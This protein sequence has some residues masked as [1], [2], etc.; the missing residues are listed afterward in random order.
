MFFRSF[1]KYLRPHKVRLVLAVICMFG[2]GFFSTYNILMAKP[3]LDVLFGLVRYEERVAEVDA[4]IKRHHGKLQ[5]LRSSDKRRDR[6]AARWKSFYYPIEHRFRVR[7]FG[8]FLFDP[9]LFKNPDKLAVIMRDGQDPLTVHLRERF[10]PATLRLLNAYREGTQP[11][12][13]LLQALTNDLN[14]VLMG[15]NL[16]DGDSYRGVHLDDRTIELLAT[17]LREEGVPSAEAFEDRLSTETLAPSD[18]AGTGPSDSRTLS[19][20]WSEKISRILMA[21]RIGVSER[22]RNV[23]LDEKTLLLLAENPEGGGNLIRLNRYLLADAYPQAMESRKRASLYGYASADKNKRKCL[24]LIAG[25]F[26]LITLCA[27]L[28]EYG[29]KY[30][31]AYALFSAVISLKSD[32]FRHIMRQD[33][34]FFT[35][36]SVGF[37]MSRITSDVGALRTM[38]DVIIK[39]A[40]LEFIRLLFLMTLLLVINVKLTAY[41]FLGVL[42]IIGLLAWFAQVIKRVTRKQKRR[43]D[44]LSAAMNESLGNVRLVKSMST[45]ELECEKFDGHNFKLFYYEMKRRIAKFGTSPIM[46]L[47]GSLG[48]GGVLLAGG[49]AVLNREMMEPSDFIIYIAALVMFYKPIKRLARVNVSWQ[50]A[51]VSTERIEEILSLQPTITDPPEDVTPVELGAVQRGLSAR[52]V[53]FAYDDKVI[54]HDLSAEFPNGKTTAIVGR[55]GSGKTTLANLLLRL[56]DPNEGQVELDGHDLRRFRVKDLRAHYGIVTQETLL[57]DATVAENIAYG[58]NGDPDR[59]RVIGAAKAANAHD[60][61]MELDGGKGYNTC[62]GPAGSQLSGGQRQRIAVARAFYRDPKILILDEATSSLDTESESAVQEALEQ[63][64]A[65]RTVVVIAHRLSTIM[66]ADN[67]L[68]LDGGRLVEQGTHAELLERGGHYA[69]LYRLGEFTES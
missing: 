28:L 60:F 20:G 25:V 18:D 2:V 27:G 53:T 49:Y 12:N 54:L 7:L 10:S 51:K 31:M 22:F 11:S 38:F 45:E 40:A 59:E 1:L 29:Y 44:V 68:V 37:L 66:H 23:E 19:D 30:N 33:M 3:A 57:F 50:D 55:S 14:A 63:L 42:P 16:H 47:L 8:S 39:N 6:I 65:H 36:K 62:I 24:R 69:T 17:A 5:E 32:I 21:E 58:T 13:A 61:I 43:R 41:V 35:V 15:E 48:V 4:E 52:N 26:V 9:S 67:I 64:M 34:R 56:Y 46:E